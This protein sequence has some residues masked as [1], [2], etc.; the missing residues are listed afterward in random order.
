MPV[1]SI[2]ALGD[3]NLSKVREL[4]DTARVWTVRYC[5]ASGY[6][7]RIRGT[8]G[9]AMLGEKKFEGGHTIDA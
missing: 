7:D 6:G 8:G 4:A 5:I 2:F 3:N 9:L 1:Y